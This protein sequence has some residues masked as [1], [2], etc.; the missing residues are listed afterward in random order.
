MKTEHLK[1]EIEIKLKS[2]YQVY[3]CIQISGP[4]Q[5]HR[6][7]A[8]SNPDLALHQYN[9]RCALVESHRILT[10]FAGAQGNQK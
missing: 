8:M 9:V 1:L 4:Q 6:K 7:T 10:F 2:N 3:E 5:R